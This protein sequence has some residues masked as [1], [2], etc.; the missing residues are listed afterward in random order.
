MNIEHTLEF[1]SISQSS[2]KPRH[3]FE[4]KDTVTKSSIFI[5]LWKFHFPQS[6]LNDKN[7]EIRKIQLGSEEIS[8][9][10]EAMLEEINHLNN[11]LEMYP[12][13]IKDLKAEIEK[14]SEKVW[15]NI[16]TCNSASYSCYRH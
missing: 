8:R 3:Y 9:H 13:T 4:Y 5:D 15:F 11:R 6:Q 16:I 14:L 7:G 10:N 12:K 2:E 1:E